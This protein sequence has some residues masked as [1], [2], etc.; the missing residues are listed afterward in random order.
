MA[1][2]KSVQ[3]QIGGRYVMIECH[4]IDKLI[5]FYKQNGFFEFDKDD[6]FDMVQMLMSIE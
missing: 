2:I 3:E 1:V 5:N 4:N 6:E